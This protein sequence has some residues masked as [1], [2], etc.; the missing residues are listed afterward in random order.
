MPEWYFSH[1]RLS[2]IK[3]FIAHEM[4]P[5]VLVKHAPTT[6]LYDVR[7]TDYGFN[8]LIYIKQLK[9]LNYQFYILNNA[10]AIDYPHPPYLCYSIDI[11]DLLTKESF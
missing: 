7:F 2:K 1:T 5:Y 8:K 11:T 9:L 3:C 6:P 10:F 4:E